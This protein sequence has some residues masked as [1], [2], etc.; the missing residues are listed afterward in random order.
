MAR[1]GG[2]SGRGGQEYAAT[3]AAARAGTPVAR[4][5]A[6]GWRA[7][8]VDRETDRTSFVIGLLGVQRSGGQR[9]LAQSRRRIAAVCIVWSA[10]CGTAIVIAINVFVARNAASIKPTKL[11]IVFCGSKKRNGIPVANI[12]FPTSV[13]GM[14]VLPLMIFHQIQRWSAQGWRGATNA[15]QKLRKSAAGKPRRSISR[16]SGAAPVASALG[17]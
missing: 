10:S 13:L 14:M 11:T 16:R 17:F 12:L 4:G 2:L 5:S 1:K 15:D 3:A 9:H 7:A 6:T 8:K